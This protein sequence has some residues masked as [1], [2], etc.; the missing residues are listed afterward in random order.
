MKQGQLRSPGGWGRGWSGKVLHG[1]GRHNWGRGGLTFEGKRG[2]DAGLVSGGDKDTFKLAMAKLRAVRF[3]RVFA[4][5][6][7]SKTIGAVF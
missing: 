5:R 6:D 3:Q 1:R 4:G 7:G 2:L